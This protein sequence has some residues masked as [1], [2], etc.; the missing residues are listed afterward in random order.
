MA[1]VV[2]NVPT[3][4]V[5]YVNAKGTKKKVV[6]SNLEKY[7]LTASTDFTSLHLYG[8][9]FDKDFWDGFRV[10]VMNGEAAN[11]VVSATNTRTDTE[12]GEEIE[13]NVMKN[14][15]FE[16]VNINC[17]CGC[18]QVHESVRICFYN[19]DDISTHCE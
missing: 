5:K 11:F 19:E 15:A 7:E 16:C 6:F 14:F 18:G 10:A 4:T 17:S 2:K 9:E 13:F 1:Y 3:I 12:T 8:C